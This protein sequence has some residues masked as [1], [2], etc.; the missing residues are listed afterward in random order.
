M[1]NVAQAIALTIENEVASGRIYNVGEETTPTIAERLRYLP[2]KPDAPLFDQP[3][4]FSQDIVYDTNAIRR[5]L[6]Y[7]EEI[8]ERDAMRD[9]CRKSV[10]AEVN[11]RSPNV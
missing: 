5:E 8:P 11:V 2:E 3:A 1:D 9:L 6:N 4:N 10:L 7:R